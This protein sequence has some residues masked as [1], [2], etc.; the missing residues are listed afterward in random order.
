MNE[1]IFELQPDILV[2]NRNLLAGDFSTPEQ[3]TQ[4]GKFDWESCM[5]INDSWAY[6]ASDNNWKSPQQ[7]VQNLVECARDGGNYLLDIGPRAD[8]SVPEQ[9]VARLNAIG[10]WLRRNGEAVYGTQRCRFPHG[11]IGVYTRKGKT[12]YT[13]IYFW[14]GKVMTV[15]GVHF[16]VKSA[17]FLAGGQ[18]VDFMQKGT[19]LIFTGLPDSAPDEPVTVIAAECD[20]EP[21][22]DALSS[23]ADSDQ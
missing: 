5:T 7:L 15:G 1:Q 2:N 9:A 11:N 17:R 10:A 19:Q 3:S 16:T 14:P 8:G 13:I 12:L 22:Q 18:P 4:P 20:T 6:L 23:K 21:V